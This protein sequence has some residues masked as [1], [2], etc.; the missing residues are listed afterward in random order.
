MMQMFCRNITATLLLSFAAMS[1]S[2]DNDNGVIDQ[3]P[4][5][6][7]R[8][9]LAYVWGDV[10][11]ESGI[12][13]SDCQLDYINK[14]EAGWDESYDGSL[15]VYLDPSPKFVQFDTPVLLKIRHD[16]TPAIVSEIVKKYD[17]IE[18]GGDVRRYPEVQ[19]DVRAI[20]PANSYGLMLFGHG[21]GIVPFGSDDDVDV[22]SR[23]LGGSEEK[24]LENREIADLT[25]PGY[26]FVILH[27]CMMA[28]VEVAYELRQKTD[29]F[30][31]SEVSLSSVG[32]PWHENLSYLYA[33]PRADLSKFVMHSCQ[34]L[35]DNLEGDE[36][37]ATLSL[38]D[39]SQLDNLAAATKKA[40]IDG[41]IALDDIRDAFI[42]K[43]HLAENC[44]DDGKGEKLLRE[45]FPCAQLDFVD[46]MRKTG[47]F[48]DEWFSSYNRACLIQVSGFRSDLE[49]YD[50]VRGN[51]ESYYNGLTVYPVMA[52]GGYSS[53]TSFKDYVDY[54]IRSYR[55][56]QWYAASGLDLVESGA[57]SKS[58]GSRKD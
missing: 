7:G 57:A 48:T 13:L 27:A 1:V 10:T 47:A 37:Y 5:Q 24:Y 22:R 17:P 15:Y 8:T 23:G 43:C 21:S 56:N 40:L 39:A 30:V 35:L 45:N 9:V 38:I 32:W 11:G 19:G 42:D 52:L 55:L 50:M 49:M 34:W 54:L 4:E 51:V 2:C 28:S 6:E 46:F 53:S 20:A 3:L 41:R 16:E 12:F 29:Y 14:M 26:E 31:A 36:K 33:K 44:M 58:G 25:L 18:A